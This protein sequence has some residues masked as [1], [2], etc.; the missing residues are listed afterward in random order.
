P[1]FARSV[2]IDGMKPAELALVL[3]GT[4][5]DL[6]YPRGAE[7][8][9]L[10]EEMDE[11]FEAIA[12]V[13]V[14]LPSMAIGACSGR[15]R[16]PG[17][18]I[19]VPGNW[20]GGPAVEGLVGHPMQKGYTARVQD[21]VGGSS[22]AQPLLHLLFMIAPAMVQCFPS[23]VEEMEARPRRAEGTHAAVDSCHMWRA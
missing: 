22:D 7:A 5:F 9:P 17:S 10:E 6:H 13:E 3:R 14:L 21:I 19:A 4:L 2:I 1:L 8:L 15:V 12:D 18:G 20:E 11:S 16:R 23:L